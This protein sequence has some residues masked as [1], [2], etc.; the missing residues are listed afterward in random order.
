MAK[1]KAV[2]VSAPVAK[3]MIVSGLFHSTQVPN[4]RRQANRL[5]CRRPGRDT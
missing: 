5:A 3:E 2:K 1:A 4:K